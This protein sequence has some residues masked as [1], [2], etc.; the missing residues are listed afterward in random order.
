M[1]NSRSRSFLIIITIAMI[2][3]LVAFLYVFAI[4]VWGKGRLNI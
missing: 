1:D 3:N 4:S 2:V